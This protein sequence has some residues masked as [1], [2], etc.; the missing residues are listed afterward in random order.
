MKTI[1]E[2]E[3]IRGTRE[4]VDYEIKELKHAVELIDEDIK[5]CGECPTLLELKARIEG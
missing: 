1:K 3:W 2:L 4:G 5:Q